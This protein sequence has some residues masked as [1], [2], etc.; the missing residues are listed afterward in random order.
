MSLEHQTREC[1]TGFIKTIITTNW[2][3]QIPP[4]IN[5]ITTNSTSSNNDIRSISF[6]TNS[7]LETLE[8]LA[9]GFIQNLEYIFSANSTKLTEIPKWC[10]AGCKNLKTCFLPLS[11]KLTTI[12]WGSFLDNYMLRCST[13]PASVSK[14]STSMDANHA[15]FHHCDQLERVYISSVYKTCNEVN[16]VSHNI[17]Y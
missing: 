12:L 14:I 5:G 8:Q 6:E 1:D 4:N 16:F 10:F 17:R 3:I 13:I 2:Y 11:G 15:T 9:F 7:L